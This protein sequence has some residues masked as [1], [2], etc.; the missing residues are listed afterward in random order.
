MERC[1][2]VL[3]REDRFGRNRDAQPDVLTDL[4]CGRA[5]PAGARCSP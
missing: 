5:V 2:R 1:V 4:R 3:D